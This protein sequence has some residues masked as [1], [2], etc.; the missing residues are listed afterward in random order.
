MDIEQMV[1]QILLISKEYGELPYKFG[2]KNAGKKMKNWRNQIF[3]INYILKKFY[4]KSSL[5]KCI[6]LTRF[7]VRIWK[8]N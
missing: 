1:L 5:R 7:D 4:C 8:K 6:M 3:F 2:P